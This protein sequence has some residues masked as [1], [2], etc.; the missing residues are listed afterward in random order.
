MK[1]STIWPISFICLVPSVSVS[2]QQTRNG[3]T[4][5]M[6]S[7]ITIMLTDPPTRGNNTRTP[8]PFRIINNLVD[9]VHCNSVITRSSVSFTVFHIRKQ[10]A[11][12]TVIWYGTSVSVL[13]F[14]VIT[15]KLFI[16]RGINRFTLVE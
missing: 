9:I 14:M 16:N 10:I 12:S 11:P 13:S 5:T 3:P 4:T 8:M 15:H 7:S 2:D 1:H 6:P